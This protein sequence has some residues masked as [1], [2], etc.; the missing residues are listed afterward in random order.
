M[1]HTEKMKA[2]LK[3]KE[4][5][6]ETQSQ[7]YKDSD[8]MFADDS[9]E[10]IFKRYVN[11]MSLYELMETLAVWE[12]E[13]DNQIQQELTL[14]QNDLNTIKMEGCWRFHENPEHTHKDTK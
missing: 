14:L 5:W 4:W 9:D 8:E 11:Q 6:I 12:E 1:E 13:L 10:D 3:Y 7:Y 2:Y